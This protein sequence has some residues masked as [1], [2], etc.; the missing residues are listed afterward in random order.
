[1]REFQAAVG[2]PIS[3]TPPLPQAGGGVE[4][5]TL[6]FRWKQARAFRSAVPRSDTTPS[7]GARTPSTASA[8][9]GIDLG[10]S[11]SACSSAESRLRRGAERHDETDNATSA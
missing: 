2:G 7:Y 3:L 5:A 6:R 4:S 9:P 8:P 1:M 11:W 10:P